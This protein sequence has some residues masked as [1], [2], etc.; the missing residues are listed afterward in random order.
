M[1]L[2]LRVGD[3]APDFRATDINGRA[4]D[5]AALRGSRVWL[6]FF[7]FAGCPLAQ[8]K[9]GK[10]KAWSAAFPTLRPIGIGTPKTA[11][12]HSYRD[13]GFPIIA[14]PDQLIFKLYG[15]EHSFQRAVIPTNQW[16][17]VLALCNGY[18]PKFPM[19]SPWFRMPADV[20]IDENGLVA[21]IHYGR[22]MHDDIARQR[23][24]AFAEP[25]AQIP[26]ATMT[27]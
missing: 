8:A 3:T 23:V 1:R 24:A 14:D 17:A 11:D 4:V 21:D 6:S 26:P 15:A 22:R 5:L 7:R 2:P 18:L 9:L 16:A 25:G 13:A 20:L 27:E 12:R 19:E 10:V